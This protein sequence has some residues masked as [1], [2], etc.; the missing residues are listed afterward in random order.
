MDRNG[1]LHTLKE[2]ATKKKK[3]KVGFFGTEKILF[4]PTHSG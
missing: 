4:S 1:E 2:R 3:K